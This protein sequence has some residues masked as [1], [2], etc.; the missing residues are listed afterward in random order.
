MLTN[1]KCWFQSLPINLTHEST[2]LQSKTQK[3]KAA[4][5]SSSHLHDVNKKEKTLSTVKVTY[6]QLDTA[7]RKL[8]KERKIWKYSVLTA[9]HHEQTEKNEVRTPYNI[10][11]VEQLQCWAEAELKQFLE[12]LITLWEQRDLSMT[13]SDS[14]NNL[15]TEKNDL[16]DILTEQ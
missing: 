11:N 7:F 10:V 5:T 16:K 4:E 2:A 12:T 13:V 9:Q 3:E 1:L 8:K 15:M 14:I 6:P